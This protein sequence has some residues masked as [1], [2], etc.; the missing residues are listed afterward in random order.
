MQPR[1]QAK[2]PNIIMIMGDD[3]GTWNTCAYHR[4]MMGQRNN[5]GSSK[6]R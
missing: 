2:K 4:G 5:E 3:V 1:A 6:F